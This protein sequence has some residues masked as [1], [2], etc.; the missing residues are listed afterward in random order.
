MCF[1]DTNRKT[2]QKK[3]YIIVMYLFQLSRRC[4][5]SIVVKFIGH[6]CTIFCYAKMLAPTINR[7]PTLISVEF[8]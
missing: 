6:I 4:R 2:V 5:V 3:V 7:I 8:L 1:A